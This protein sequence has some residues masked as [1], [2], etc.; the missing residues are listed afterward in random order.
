MFSSITLAA[1]A[2][3]AMVIAALQGASARERIAH[4]RIFAAAIA[5]G[6]AWIYLRPELLSLDAGSSLLLKVRDQAGVP[7]GRSVQ[8]VLQETQQTLIAA[9]SF[10]LAFIAILRPGTRFAQGALLSLPLVFLF[11]LSQAP[12][13][14]GVSVVGE[15]GV[16]SFLLVAERE[17]QLSRDLLLGYQVPAQPWRYLPLGLSL[18]SA[19]IASALIGVVSSALR[20]RPGW[21]TPWTLSAA[22]LGLTGYVLRCLETGGVAFD[23]QSLTSLLVLM[24]I[25]VGLQSRGAVLRLSA[26]LSA[27]ALTI[28]SSL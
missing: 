25:S 20:Q 12:L 21:V 27:L 28:L 22:L 16:E 10:G 15:S 24:F 8:M 23:P 26:G 11:W 4:Q 17:G 1:C 19:M 3:V 14:P 9:L 2:S 13:L 7:Q 18:I 6:A 5:A